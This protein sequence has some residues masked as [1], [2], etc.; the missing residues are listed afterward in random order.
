ML[1]LDHI[2]NS[3]S[4]CSPTIIA[5]TLEAET[6]ARRPISH[7]RRK[8][9]SVVPEAKIRSAGRP[10]ASWASMVST[11]HGLETIT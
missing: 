9:S 3:V 6:R 11:S 4:P 7:R 5:C 8:V 1:A 10:L 2:G